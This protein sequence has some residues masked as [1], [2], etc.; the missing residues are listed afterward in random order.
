MRLMELKTNPASIPNFWLVWPDQRVL[1][2][3]SQ[4]QENI[5]VRWDMGL[6]KKRLAYFC[7]PKAN[8]GKNKNK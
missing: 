1:I 5:S 6:N 2:K 4:T 8:E 3:E 7:L